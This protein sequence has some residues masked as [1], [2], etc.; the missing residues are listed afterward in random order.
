ML[1]SVF[2]NMA[3]NFYQY[4]GLQDIFW[5]C[6]IIAIILGVG[7]LI[8]SK[9]AVTL[10]LVTCIPSQFMWLFNFFLEIFLDGFGQ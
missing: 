3:K 4:G 2:I 1:L 6:N 8:K 7:I 10:A 5:F 9:K